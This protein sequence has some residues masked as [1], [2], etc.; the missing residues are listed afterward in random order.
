M[1]TAVGDNTSITSEFQKIA[2]AAFNECASPVVDVNQFTV[3]A[4]AG[5]T[6]NVGTLVQGNVFTID[7]T[8]VQQL[9]SN[10]SLSSKM[11]TQVTSTVKAQ[12]SGLLGFLS[13]SDAA[14]INNSAQKLAQAIQDQTRNICAAQVINANKV[15][16]T[17]TGKSTINAYN[18]SQT[19]KDTLIAQCVQNN[20]TVTGA[21][22]SLKTAIAATTTATSKGIGGGFL[23]MLIIGAI[24][25][26]AGL[27]WYALKQYAWIK[28]IVILIVL[29]AVA[30]FVY[31]FVEKIGPFK[32]APTKTPVVSPDAKI[33]TPPVAPKAT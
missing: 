10:T 18:I 13:P 14:N 1:A 24:V 2:T 3:T 30:V 12:T 6:V 11:Q 5:S 16:L 21:Q 15:T 23:L 19:N 31:L 8:C 28:W 25:V 26:V 4:T 17:A 9:K 20:T 29:I 7:A 32:P 33:A 27:I 22:S